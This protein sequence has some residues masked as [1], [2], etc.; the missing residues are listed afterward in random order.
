VSCNLKSKPP[1][2]AGIAESPQSEKADELIANKDTYNNVAPVTVTNLIYL[3]PTLTEPHLPTHPF[4]V[5]S[6]YE[7]LATGLTD[8]LVDDLGIMDKDLFTEHLMEIFRSQLEGDLSCFLTPMCSFSSW[9]PHHCNWELPQ[10]EQAT[11]SAG[12]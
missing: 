3:P 10:W 12:S 5:S 7:P 4:A 8:T 6:Q 11:A 1:G 9:P 2:I